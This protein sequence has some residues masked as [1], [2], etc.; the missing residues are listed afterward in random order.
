MRWCL[1]V[2]LGQIMD[3]LAKTLDVILVNGSLG[4]V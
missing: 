2:R 3:G 4:K 1:R